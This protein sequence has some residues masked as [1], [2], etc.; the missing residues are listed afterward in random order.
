MYCAFPVH[1]KLHDAE[2]GAMR[3]GL[4]PEYTAKGIIPMVQ[5]WSKLDAKRLSC[6][7][8]LAGPPDIT[9]DYTVWWN[10]VLQLLL[11]QSAAFGISAD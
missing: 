3:I 10:L 6:G 2:P 9:D 8:R 1:R 4:T 5:H 7:R 11:L